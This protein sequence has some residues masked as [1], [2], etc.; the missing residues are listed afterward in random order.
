MAGF[1]KCMNDRI[2]KQAGEIAKE[3]IVEL[4]VAKGKRVYIR[5]V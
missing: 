4:K 3:N 2:T 5:K 1:V